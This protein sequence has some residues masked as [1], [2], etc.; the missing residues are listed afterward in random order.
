M[1]TESLQVSAEGIKI[2]RFSFANGSYFHEGCP[3]WSPFGVPFGPPL[4][5]F[6]TT[7]GLL[8]NSFWTSQDSVLEHQGFTSLVLIEHK[9]SRITVDLLVI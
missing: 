8:L 6:W 1:R 2:K 4:G 5:L 3:F 9:L 7:F